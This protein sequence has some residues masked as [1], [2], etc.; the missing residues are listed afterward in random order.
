[1]KCTCPTKATNK[2]I[3]KAIDYYYDCEGN[4]HYDV[5]LKL[6]EL[7]A[8][9]MDKSLFCPVHGKPDNISYKAIWGLN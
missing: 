6:I 2:R 1:M 7:S 4:K 5:P 8:K 9:A 3:E